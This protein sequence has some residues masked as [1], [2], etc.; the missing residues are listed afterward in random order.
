MTD[1]RQHI[2]C[3]GPKSSGRQA[4]NRRGG[5]FGNV[6]CHEHGMHKP[7]EQGGCGQAG[8]HNPEGSFHRSITSLLVCPTV[9]RDRAWK[10]DM[11]LTLLGGNWHVTF[12]PAKSSYR[13]SILKS[14]N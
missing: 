8:E 9:R 2:D 7:R 3:G 6:R 10:C 1:Q 12:V 14:L 4:V 11:G 13:S 5:W